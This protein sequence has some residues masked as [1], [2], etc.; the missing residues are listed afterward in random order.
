MARSGLRMVDEPSEGILV[1]STVESSFVIDVKS[2]EHL[3][4]ILMEL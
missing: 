1:H 4:A 3:D 2:K